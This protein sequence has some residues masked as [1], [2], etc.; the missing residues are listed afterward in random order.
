MHI[1]HDNLVVT[2]ESDVEQKI[3]FPLLSGSAYLDI[4]QNCIFTK[5]YLAPSVLDKSAGR[6]T[7][8]YPDYSVWMHGFPVLIV[9]AKA[10]DIASE[11]G[12]REAGMYARQLNQNYPADINPCR[13]I[14]ST[15]GRDL[16]FGHWDCSPILAIPVNDVRPG[17]SAF[18]KLM[19]QCH[20]QTL[21]HLHS[22][23]LLEFELLTRI[24]HITWLMVR[25]Y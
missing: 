24:T 22:D 3:I 23:V 2:N 16:L 6:T 7:G 11:L 14:I 13:F 17:A 1:D 20:S 5:D 8:Y 15:N 19:E 9:E 18:S 21:Y 25:L 4:P 12:Y 10:P